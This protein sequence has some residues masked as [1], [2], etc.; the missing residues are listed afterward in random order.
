MIQYFVKATHTA[1]AGNHIYSEGEKQ[2]WFIGKGG[3]SRKKI[4]WLPKGGW[5]RRCYAD[6]YIQ[7]CKDYSEELKQHGGEKWTHEYEVVEVEK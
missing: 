6:Q 4:T 7:K 2:T 5:S 3:Y 1:T